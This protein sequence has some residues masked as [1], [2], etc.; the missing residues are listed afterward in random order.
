MIEDRLFSQQRLG[1]LLV[2]RGYISQDQLSIALLEQKHRRKPLG[3]VLLELCFID[4]LQLQEVLSENLQQVAFDLEGILVQAEILTLISKEIARQYQVFPVAWNAEQLVLTL[5]MVNPNNLMVLDRIKMILPRD[6]EIN[7]VLATESGLLSAIDK[8]YGYEHSIDSILDEMGSVGHIVDEHVFKSSDMHHYPVVRLVDALLSDAIQMSASDIHLEPEAGFIRIRYRI[9]GVL[10]QI[11]SIHRSYW[12]AMVV[13]IK[14]I[15]SMNI[16]ETRSPQDG[17]LSLVLGNK[18]VDF[19][20]ATQPTL[21]GENIVIRILDRRQGLVPLEGL[22]LSDLNLEILKI[23]LQRPEGVILVTGPTGSGKTTTLY[24][25]LNYLNTEGVN[26][27]TLEDPVEYAIT[28]IRQTTLSDAN[29]I[30]YKT[31]IKSLMRQDPDII[32]VG[33][34]RD[35]ESAE[36]VFRAALTGHKVFTTVHTNSAL[37]SLTRLMDIGI[38][39]MIMVNTISA[40]LAQRLVRRLCS[41]CKEAYFPSN[42]EKEIMGIVADIKIYRSKGCSACNGMGYKGR[43]AIIE[44]IRVNDELDHLISQGASSYHLKHWQK[45][46][47]ILTLLDDGIRR[48]VE[49]LTSLDEISRVVDFTARRLG[50]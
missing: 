42:K 35:K 24:A 41:A 12:P 14:V 13:R 23:T 49:G 10:R 19:R 44:L 18:Q 11:R 39:P 34:V 3:K 21:H 20:V 38:Q 4:E 22:G 5:A 17:H 45:E 31:G 43:V 48:V 16:A 32:L 30:D 26:I 40:I 9:D 27:M 50:H 33:E 2:E 46:S 37:G 7:P 28:R 1:E 15:S 36:M 47:G 8:H 6:V 25:I 29:K